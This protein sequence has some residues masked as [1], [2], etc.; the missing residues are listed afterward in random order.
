[1]TEILALRAAGLGDLLT[2]VPALRA[3]RRAGRVTLVTPGWLAPLARWARVAD[4]LLDA[5]GLGATPPSLRP[6]VAVNLHGRG[7][8]SHRWLLATH[9]D[10]LVAFANPDVAASASGPRWDDDDHEVL[11]WCR[12]VLDAGY[13]PD[14]H[15]LR[16]AT[17]PD[18]LRGT[19]RGRRAVLHPGA[20]D[21]ARRWPAD[22]WSVIARA[23]GERGYEIVLTGAARERALASRV[24]RRAGLGRDAVLAG[25]TDVLGLAGVVAHAHLVVSGDTGVAHLAAALDRPAVAIY[26]PTS[27]SRWGPAPS[28][29]RT[30][31]WAGVES[32]PHATRP[33]PGLLA[34][35]ADA[36]ISA[37]D[38]LDPRIRVA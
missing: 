26:G 15:D 27:P 5:D 6:D 16:I 9:P 18:P 7:P 20:K 31:L 8:E 33:A 36:V 3:L 23:L 13:D 24:A 28:A 25:E 11:R 30:V 12:L 4:A 37:I 34:I 35:G 1:M 29:G 17:P 14:P 19:A 21:P 10:R 22:R 38:A 2:V 32:D